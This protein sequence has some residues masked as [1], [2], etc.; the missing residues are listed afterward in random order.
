MLPVFGIERRE[1]ER[2][3]KGEG[4]GAGGKVRVSLDDSFFVR[5]SVVRSRVRLIRARSS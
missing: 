1:R 2:E 4:E 3:G 5:V